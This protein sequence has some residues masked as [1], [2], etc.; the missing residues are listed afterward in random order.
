MA[1]SA[2][3]IATYVF[4]SRNQDQVGQDLIMEMHE[5][6]YDSDA[7][8]EVTTALSNVFFILS[9]PAKD[10]SAPAANILGS[11]QIITS[12]AVTVAATASNSDVF[13]VAFFGTY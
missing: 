3:K 11:D 4:D 1:A 8:V 7:T 6:T 2:L 12:G 5:V 9:G 10:V 13:R